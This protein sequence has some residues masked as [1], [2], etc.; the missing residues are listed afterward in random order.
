MDRNTRRMC[1]GWYTID[2]IW[3]FYIYV[4]VGLIWLCH[5]RNC[6]D[7]SFNLSDTIQQIYNIVDKME[8]T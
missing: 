1:G 6:F 3:L 7:F 8:H 2:R 4:G 5:E